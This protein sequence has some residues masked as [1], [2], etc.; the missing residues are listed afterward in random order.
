MRSKPTI[1]FRAF[2]LIELLVVIA[3]IAILAAI[4]FPVFAQAREKARMSAC[5]SNV[6][7]IGLGVMMYVGDY[8]ERFPNTKAWGRMWT[9]EWVAN[10]ANPDSLRYLPDMIGPY[11][12]NRDIWFC[13]SIGKRGAPFGFWGTPP[14]NV[15]PAEANGTTY[16]WQHQTQDCSLCTPN[17]GAVNVTGLPQA[18]VYAPAQA[19]ILHDIP[20]HGWDA[21]T[22]NGMHM[23]GVNVAYA[24]GH[25]KFAGGIQPNE[26]WW[27]TH[28]CLGWTE[29]ASR[30]TKCSNQ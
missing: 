11:T 23:K 15:D 7:Q 17:P 6:K 16:L 14:N 21:G 20:Y 9:G 1:R 27:S 26:D 4:L 13:P 10:P 22:Q 24:D 2:T 30:V 3:I 12:K 8:D 25:A 19:P 29:P 18:A 28:S 5:L